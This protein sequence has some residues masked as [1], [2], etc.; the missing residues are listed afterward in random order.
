MTNYRR[1]PKCNQPNEPGALACAYCGAELVRR[2][3]NCGTPRPWNVA[4]CPN[5]Q[6]GA[7]DSALFADLFRRSRTGV[8]RGRYTLL[9]TLSA[10]PVT[11][12][13]RASDVNDPLRL[14]AVKELSTVSLFRAEERREAGSSLAHAI[15]RWSAVRHAGLAPIIDH[16][17]D[18]ERH[19]VVS[20]YV[21]G[22]SGEQILN[23]PSLRI[24]PE[25][26]R[27]W[28]AQVCD[29]L[30]FL[31]ALPDPLF[32]PFLAPSHLIA[33]PEGTIKLVGYGLG[34][35]V[36]PLGFGP[37]GGVPGYAA[38]DLTQRPPDALSDVFSLGR[39]LYALLI[40]RPL[41][42]GLPRGLN[43]QQVVPG[44]SA[45]MVRLIARAATSRR[46]RRFSSARELRQALWDDS[47][48]SLQPEAGW[49]QRSRTGR[50][51]VPST[52]S[53]QAPATPKASM[54]DMGYAR[55]PRYGPREVSS[56]ATVIDQPTADAP[57]RQSTARM[58][59]HPTGFDVRELPAQGIKR[60]VLTVR[61]S[62]QD[63]L[64]FRISSQVAWLKAPSKQVMLTAGKQARV[65]LSVDPALL[66]TE[67]A[68]ETQA[69]LLDSNVGRQ[70]VPVTVEVKTAPLL[71]VEPLALDF[72]QLE[73]GQERTLSVTVFNDG[74]Q[75]LDCQ[76]AARVPWLSARPPG[77]RIPPAASM[78]VSVRV[79][80]AQ[81]PSGQQ[82]ASDALLIDSNGGQ[83]RISAD[84]WLPVPRLE[85]TSGVLDLNV[86]PVD[87]VVTQELVIRNA[88]DGELRGTARSLVP[89]LQVTP[90]DVLCAEGSTCALR[91]SIDTT[92]L[93]DGPLQVPQA[94]RL[95]T[96]G[97]AATLPARLQVSAPR[98][99]LE[100]AWLQ[101]GQ[102]TLGDTVSREIIVR[103][104]GSAPLVA[105]ITSGLDWLQPAADIVTCAPGES[106][107]VAVTVKTAAL[108]HGGRLDLPA[109]LRVACGSD[110]QPVGVSIVVL[111]PVLTVDP[112][113]VDFGYLDPA[114]P[115]VIQLTLTNQGTGDLAW[116]AQSDAEWLEIQ[117]ASGRCAEGA[118]MSVSLTAYALG[119]EAGRDQATG[120]L[121]ITSDAGRIKVP[122]RVAVAAPRLEVDR[123]FVDLG[124]SVNRQSVSA[125][126]RVFNR[127]LGL[128]RG[129]AISDRLW[130]VT[131][132][133]SFEC[134][135][136]HSVELTIRTDMDEFAEDLAEDR[137][138]ISI[139]TNGGAV[140]IDIRVQVSRR[141]A[142]R[143]PEPVVLKPAEPGQGA[144]GRLVL[145]ND[146]LAT[147][148]V[149]V[150]STD[151]RLVV[152]REQVEVKQD[153]SVRVSV[154]WQGDL[155][156]GQE[157][158]FLIVTSEAGSWQVPVLQQ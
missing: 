95:Q 70:W 102:V 124:S 41:E 3:P 130:L 135:T 8:L 72:G 62:G 134:D 77:L 89:W 29:L 98:L 14:Y 57:E 127:G 149:G 19:Y 76:V 93:G 110:V 40:D 139:E 113:L 17:E 108:G 53:R 137:G 74:R 105:S 16:F 34:Y 115:S 96:N 18:H 9:E 11:T 145:R 56:S 10:G 32:A 2:C 146:G 106:Q 148:H 75:V 55:D 52:V 37:Y 63:D 129:T 60:L 92:G 45:Q 122:L 4:L 99:A 58:S 152:S 42:K 150:S 15:Q 112:A 68:S 36:R 26:A 13:Y 111:Q 54:E 1:C 65:V 118:Q 64:S 103:N 71:R 81:L 119:M 23:D 114:T 91:V 79:I 120:T 86:V 104:V 87:T 90:E 30:A 66:R 6:V 128:L 21:Y 44:I 136:G 83:A 156:I 151:A 84:A 94:L 154:S 157:G 25:L 144:Q 48:G 138:V 50:Q 85:L 59:V 117:P 28:G 132:R 80:E 100:P 47:R 123:T 153:K 158:L 39:T 24:D 131:D 109:A 31:H 101:F 69:L 35:H 125:S 143:D 142:L 121:A 27:N 43:L 49:Y 88:G 7:D 22:W 12:V 107:S 78:P 116:H 38:P 67:R 97:G 133:T 5:C 126:V 147:A 20:E 155:P 33:T 141:P 61:N 46:D 51:A 140:D 82:H 73:N